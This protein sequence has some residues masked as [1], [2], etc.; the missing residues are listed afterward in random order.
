VKHL[1]ESCLNKLEHVTSNLANILFDNQVTVQN[2]KLSQETGTNFFSQQFKPLNSNMVVQWSFKQEDDCWYYENSGWHSVL[3][4]T[5]I[6]LPIYDVVRPAEED[7]QR[8]GAVPYAKSKFVRYARS[9]VGKRLRGYIRKKIHMLR[10]G[11]K[12]N[13]QPKLYSANLIQQG[14]LTFELTESVDGESLALNCLD[15]GGIYTQ[16]LNSEGQWLPDQV[17]VSYYATEYAAYVFWDQYKKTADKKWLGAVAASLK[18]F[19]VNPQPY[20]NIAFDH[21]EFK[22]MPLALLVTELQE[23][24]ILSELSAS[25]KSII[26]SEWRIYSPVN[27]YA[28]RLANYYLLESLGKSPHKSIP[29]ICL[30]ML[31]NNQAPSGLIKDNNSG[32]RVNNC[33]FTYH[34]YSLACLSFAGDLSN[35]SRIRALVGKGLAFSDHIQLGDG[36]VSYFG[37]GSNN[38]YHLAA[39]AFAASNSANGVE[40][41]EN[42]LDLISPHLSNRRGLPTALNSGFKARMAWNHC[43]TPYNAMTAFFLILGM[44]RLMSTTFSEQAPPIKF[45]SPLVDDVVRIESNSGIA[46]F[47]KGSDMFPWSDGAHRVGLGGLCGFSI[48]KINILLSLG[49][50]RADDMWASDLPLDWQR[51]QSRSLSGRLNQINNKVT[52]SNACIHAEYTLNRNSMIFSYN[53]NSDLGESGLIGALNIPLNKIKRYEMGTDSAIITLNSDVVLRTRFRQTPGI[54]KMVKVKSNPMGEG[55]R[56]ELYEPGCGNHREWE[57][58]YD[59]K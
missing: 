32:A 40:V 2:I 18:H 26:N 29:S 28:L 41:F 31:E 24:H 27:V 3:D 1:P 37:R 55:L 25:V 43:A 34:Q 51:I 10:F 33:D 23:K 4:Q 49:Y 21:F 7:I 47:T 53:I 38:I 22:I 57:L 8:N 44:K 45:D 50:S 36:H 15:Y 17:P 19:L 13:Q 52:F 56:F 9:D 58:L 6:R 14:G 11:D 30:K 48:G 35:S 59:T 5:L 46:V 39:Y 20:A 12:T 42:V 54:I 16:D